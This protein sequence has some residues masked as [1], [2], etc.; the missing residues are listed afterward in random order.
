[1]SVRRTLGVVG[2][3]L[4]G[5]VSASESSAPPADPAMVRALLGDIGMLP[6]GARDRDVTAALRRFQARN[7]L[8]V[9]GAAGPLTC[10]ALSRAA[11]EARELHDLGFAA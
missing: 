1:M 3:V 5:T 7:G 8:T 4:A 2:A 11:R 9:D 6:R 10:R